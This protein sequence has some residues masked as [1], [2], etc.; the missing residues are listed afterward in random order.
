MTATRQYFQ[1]ERVP[2]IPLPSRTPMNI[3]NY[4][5][6]VPAMNSAAAIEKLLVEAGAT[7]VSKW[8]VE[9]EVAGFLFQMQVNG[10]PR[11]FRLPSDVNKVYGLFI[12]G[13]ARLDAGQRLKLKAQ[14]GRTAWRTLHEL[15]QIQVAMILLEQVD[16]LQVFL[17]YNYDE[18][19]GQTIYDQAKAGSLKL[20][21]A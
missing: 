2:L 3:K 6:T 13:K 1:N 19:T 11:V 12:R 9:K 20:L 4:T 16:P 14:A 8:Y 10:V 21:G 15:V 7:S 17:A 5:S 18:A